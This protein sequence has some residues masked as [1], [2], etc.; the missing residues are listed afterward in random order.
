MAAG[1]GPVEINGRLDAATAATIG[2]YESDAGWPVT[3]EPSD[4]LLIAL[5]ATGAAR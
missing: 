3:G 5:M 2:R 1:Y 4:R